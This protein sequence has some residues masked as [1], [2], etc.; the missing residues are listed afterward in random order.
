LGN[1]PH[2]FFALKTVRSDKSVPRVCG[3]K[4]DAIPRWD[5]IR[6]V[7]HSFPIYVMFFLRKPSCSFKL[8]SIDVQKNKFLET[9]FLPETWGRFSERFLAV[10][11]S[12]MGSLRK[13]A[14]SF[15]TNF[16]V[17]WSSQGALDFHSST[18]SKKLVI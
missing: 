8:C 11:F 12:V 5:S 10:T 9:K 6:S 7:H 16:C 3:D 15:A 13:E 18:H 4:P 2:F 1:K 14:R 17:D